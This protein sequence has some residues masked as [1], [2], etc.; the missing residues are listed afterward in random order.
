MEEVGT[1]SLRGAQRAL[2]W[3]IKLVFVRPGLL[4]QREGPG[5][6]PGNSLVRPDG[7]A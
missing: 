5:S 4:S 2:S 7:V 1:K 3:R 6:E